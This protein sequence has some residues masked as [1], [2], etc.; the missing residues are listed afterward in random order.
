MKRPRG[1]SPFFAGVGTADV[2]EGD[3]RRLKT[4]LDRLGVPCEARYYE[5]EIHA[6][7]AMVWRRN[8]KRFWRDTFAFL[9]RHVPPAPP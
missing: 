6:F 8:A 9:A 5:G 2:L 4:A 7:H 1:R 3:T